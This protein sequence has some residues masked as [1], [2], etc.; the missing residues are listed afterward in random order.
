MDATQEA[1]LLV[2]TLARLWPDLVRLA[3]TDVDGFEAAVLPALREVDAALDG[4]DADAVTRAQAS[5]FAAFTSYPAAETLLMQELAAMI[6]DVTRGARPPL[7]PGAVKQDRYLDVPVCYATDRRPTGKADPGDRFGGERGTGLVF[8]VANVS[9]PDDHRMGALE[10]PGLWRLRFRKD[11]GRFVTV[12][13]VEPAQRAPFVERVRAAVAGTATPDVLIF[14]HGYNVTF[15]DAVRRAAQV[16]YDLHFE[17][18][19]MLYS[20]PSKASVLGYGADENNVTWTAPHFAEFLRL[21]MTEL[22]ARRVHAVAHSMGNR[23]L[24]AGLVD[25]DATD[26]PQLG[27]VVFAAPDIDAAVF[28]QLAGKFTGNAAGCTLYASSND[29]ALRASEQWATHPRAGQSGP[30]IVVVPGVDTIDA[31]ELDTGLMGHSYYG[32]RR[33]VLADMFYVI[34]NGLA[35][36]ARFGLTA[37]SHPSGLTYWSFTPGDA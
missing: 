24:L 23:V 15:T 35:P 33:S 32:D 3:D 37:M 30:D 14:V 13:A 8:G 17:G 4:G 2:D 19:P 9:I 12:L 34:R 29:L 28:T 5:V 21:A 18:V 16:A 1:L 20:W 27:Q 6:H 22:G 11:P 31:S 25:L 7:L 10:K 26:S 36:A